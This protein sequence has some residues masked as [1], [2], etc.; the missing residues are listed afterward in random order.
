M[1]IAAEIGGTFVDL[2][3][4]DEIDKLCRSKCS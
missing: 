3:A 2:V 4:G 1:K